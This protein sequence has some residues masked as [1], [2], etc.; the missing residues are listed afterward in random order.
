MKLASRIA[1]RV[2]GGSHLILA[3]D[4]IGPVLSTLLVAGTLAMFIAFQHFADEEAYRSSH[5]HLDAIAEPAAP[6]LGN[7][8]SIFVTA[9]APEVGAGNGAAEDGGAAAGWLRGAPLLARGGDGIGIAF[10]ALGIAAS[11]PLRWMRRRRAAGA[12]RSF[13][14]SAIIAAVNPIL[15]GD[16]RKPELP[17]VFANPAFT[18]FPGFEC[19][20]VTGRSIWWVLQRIADDNA[21]AGLRQA[22][23]GGRSIK[24][25]SCRRGPDGQDRWCELQLAPTRTAS[26]EIGHFAVVFVDI[27]RRKNAETAL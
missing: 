12:G 7:F 26:G 2:K 6:S 14:E 27:T 21:V 19:R 22:L 15:I 20:N 11:P 23:E 16:A 24:V 10:G 13:Y 1:A 4:G 18:A 25:E 9:A 8:D 17:V 5:A 3:H